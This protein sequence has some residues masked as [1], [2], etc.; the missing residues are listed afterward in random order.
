[1]N[2]LW[3]KPDKTLAITS[4]FESDDIES[5]DID[6][7]AKELQARGDI[8]A[9]WTLAGTN[10]TWPDNPLNLPHE[11][12][13]WVK[14]VIVADAVASAA[15]QTGAVTAAISAALDAMAQTHGYDDIA[16]ACR[17][18]SQAPAV[19][20]TDANFDMCEKFRAEGN[21]LQSWMS[22]T[23]AM[24]LGYIAAVKSGSKPMPTA[25]EA[26]AMMPT[27]AWPK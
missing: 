8:D 14:G 7:H 20:S 25:D 1:M 17:Y 16:S 6:A 22:L 26:V 21:A 9:S 24:A 5:V 15:S 11:C 27:F 18:A 12:F 19:A 23:W 10:V 3:I 13:R 2:I 4:V